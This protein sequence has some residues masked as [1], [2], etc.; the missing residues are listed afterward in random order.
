MNR[1]RLQRR[2]VNGSGYADPDRPNRGWIRVLTELE[3]REQLIE[4]AK[5]RNVSLSTVVREALWKY[6]RE[7]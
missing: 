4:I 5:E 2:L 1:S 7:S 6:I 3:L